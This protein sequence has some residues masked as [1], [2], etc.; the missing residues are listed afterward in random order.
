MLWQVKDLEETVAKTAQ[1]LNRSESQSKVRT[2]RVAL[3]VGIDLSLP[4]L[5]E[6]PLLRAERC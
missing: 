3:F 2:S 5:S 6:I 1:T 4:I